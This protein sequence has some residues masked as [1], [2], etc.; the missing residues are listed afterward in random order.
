[1]FQTQLQMR[2]ILRRIVKRNGGLT[3]EVQA[4]QRL[5]DFK[6]VAGSEGRP[7]VVQNSAAYPAFGVD[8]VGYGRWSLHPLGPSGW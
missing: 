3:L 6:F 2:Y 7:S 4:A 5:V 8:T 1:M